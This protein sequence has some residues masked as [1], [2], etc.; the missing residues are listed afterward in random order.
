MVELVAGS[1]GVFEVTVENRL[2][3]SKRRLNRFPEQGE[4]AALIGRFDG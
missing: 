4:I 1:G 3:F 2:L